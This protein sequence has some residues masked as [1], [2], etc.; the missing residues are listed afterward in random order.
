MGSGRLRG[1][2]GSGSGDYERPSRRTS[3]RA[4]RGQPEGA[5]GLSAPE[6]NT[7]KLSGKASG[8]G[9]WQTKYVGTQCGLG[10]IYVH[11]KFKED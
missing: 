1:S 7:G 5:S 8:P 9:F 11:I 2:R 3:Q 6:Q 4:A 10:Y